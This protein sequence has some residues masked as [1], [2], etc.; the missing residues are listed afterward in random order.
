MTTG[1]SS[2]TLGNT[3]EDSIRTPTSTIGKI[4]GH[5]RYDAEQYDGHQLDA[6]EHDGRVG[7][8]S[9]W[10]FLRDVFEKRYVSQGVRAV[11]S[12]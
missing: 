2:T 11:D 8:Q 12:V 9:I 1:T 6:A 3:L 5:Q 4:D 10:W 7:H